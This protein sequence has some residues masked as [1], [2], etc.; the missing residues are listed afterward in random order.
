MTTRVIVVV[1]RVRGAVATMGWMGRWV[2]GILLI[3]K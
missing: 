2:V 3:A 1:G